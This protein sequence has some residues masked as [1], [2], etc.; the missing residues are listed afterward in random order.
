MMRVLRVLAW[1]ALLVGLL[2]QLWLKDRHAAW[3]LFFYAMPK[4]CLMAWLYC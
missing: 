4:P 2:L 1:L 3:A